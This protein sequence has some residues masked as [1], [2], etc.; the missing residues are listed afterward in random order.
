[1]VQNVRYLLKNH[2]YLKYQKNRP[3]KYVIN[4]L[5]HAHAYSHVF[6]THPSGQFKA[7]ITVKPIQI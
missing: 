3:I 4:G 6:H 5:E 7:Q 1:M 2:L